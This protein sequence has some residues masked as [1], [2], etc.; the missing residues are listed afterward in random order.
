MSEKILRNIMAGWLITLSAT[1]Y[2]DTLPFDKVFVYGSPSH[3]EFM[4]TTSYRA[5]LGTPFG[6]AAVALDCPKNTKLV[7]TCEDKAQ[8]YYGEELIGEIGATDGDDESS[9]SRISDIGISLFAEDDGLIDFGSGNT[10][11]LF[12][13]DQRRQEQYMR[14][15]EYTLKVPEGL[16]AIEGNPVGAGEMKYNYL[17]NVKQSYSYTVTPEPGSI[18]GVDEPMKTLTL[19]ITPDIGYINMIDYE[20]PVGGLWGP[21]GRELQFESSY[22]KIDGNKIIWS[23]KQ[24]PRYRF[25]WVAGEYTFKLRKNTINVNSF[26]GEGVAPVFPDEDINVLYILTEDLTGVAVTGIEAAQS[27]TVHTLD[28]RLL[29]ADASSDF[30][31]SLPRGVYIING[32]KACLSR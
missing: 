5:E 9:P 15:G 24:H 31:L 14:S 11:W 16:F 1:V 19:E 13:F 6:M 3:P 12:M 8:L 32:R 27:Y 4:L 17:G 22:A 2:G 20:R 26:S 28:G 18:F 7:V 21:N 29:A 25:D 30:L 10:T 23:F